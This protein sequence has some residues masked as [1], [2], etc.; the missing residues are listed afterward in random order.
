MS[1]PIL[2]FFNNKGGVGKTSLIYHLSWMFASLGKRVVVA[3]LD[4]QANLTAA[5]LNEDQIDELWNNSVEGSTVFQCVKPLT[6]VGDIT[7]PK[8]QQIVN[9]LYL[10]PGD[11]AL[12]SYEDTLAGEWPK[13]MADTNLYRPM[14]IL[15]SFW[16]VMQTAAIKV[17]AEIILVDIGPNL[18]AINR[19]VLLAT[20]YVIIPLG[21][22]LFSLQGLKNLG[23]A[24]KSWRNL[25]QKRLNNWKSSSEPSHYPNFKLPTGRMQP[26][27]YLSQQH[28]VRLDRPVKAYDK[29]I[30][31][32]PQ[33]Y[34]ESVLD[35]VS[36]DQTF[37]PEND[38][39]RL[40]TIKHYRSLMPMAQECRKPIFNLTAADGAIGSHANAVLDAKK[41]FKE[42]A[43]IVGEKIDLQL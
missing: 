37:L 9:N 28:T 41:D 40:G 18:G 33:V 30:N 19:S 26:I 25:W 35:G 16:H 32:I 3:D 27:G 14:R 21:A 13:S 20:D 5:F 7:E 23:P 4:P 6:G 34:R 1:I 11:V 2:T 10:I 15:S 39:Y 38:Q 17:D 12:S 8:L 22:D 42:L 24:L 36:E 43:K 31:R 29:W